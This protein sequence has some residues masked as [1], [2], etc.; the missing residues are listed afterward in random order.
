MTY[1]HLQADCLYTGISSGPN[2]PY[3]VW[4][5]FTYLPLMSHIWHKFAFE[6]GKTTPAFGFLDIPATTLVTFRVSRSRDAKCIV[7]SRVCVSVC[8]SAA[9][10]LH[11]CTDPDVTWESGRDARPLST[12]GRICNWCT[13]CVA[14]AT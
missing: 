4:E 11:Y 5:A 2:A 1:G 12:I 6:V 7:V 3:R 9:T 14:M 13:G 8:L 10:C